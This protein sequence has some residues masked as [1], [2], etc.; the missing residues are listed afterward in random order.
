MFIR[1]WLT[2]IGLALLLS[3]VCLGAVDAHDELVYG[4]YSRTIGPIAIKYERRMSFPELN[5]PAT[6]VDVELGKAIFSFDG[7]GEVRIWPLPDRCPVWSRCRTFGNAR[8]A[9]YICQAEELKVEG[10]WKRYFGFLCKEGAAVVPARDVELYNTYGSPLIR[11][12]STKALRLRWGLMVPGSGH[13]SLKSQEELCPKI[14]DPLHVSLHL[15]NSDHTPLEVPSTWYKNAR[16]GPALREGLTISLHWAGFEPK[17]P[18]AG[19]AND[20]LFMAVDAVGDRHFEPDGG[21]HTLQ[22]AETFEALTLDLHDWFKIERDGYYRVRFELDGDAPGLT[23]RLRGFNQVDA[24]FTIGMPP[25]QPTVAEYNAQIHPLGGP[26]NEER[27]KRLIKETAKAKPR[28]A[29]P[30]PAD[31]EALLAWSKPVNGLAGRIEF[32]WQQRNFWQQKV[33]LV[34]LKNVSDQPLTIPMGNPSDAK[35]PSFFDV[36]AQ[37]GSSPWRRATEFG[38][39]NRYVPAPSDPKA[40]MQAREPLRL[41]KL[42]PSDRPWVTLAPGQESIALAAG[43]DKKDTG[44]AKRVKVVLQQPD[45]SIP[46]RWS[47]VLETPPRAMELPEEQLRALRAVLPFPDHF[48]PLSYEDSRWYTTS[49]VEGLHRSNEPLIDMLPIYDPAGVRKEFDRRMQAEK[50]PQMKLLLASIAAGVGS[51]E[52][53]LFFLETKKDT[54]Y[55]TVLSLHEALW[56]TYVNCTGGPSEWETA[57]LPDWLAELFLTIISD[58]R[59]VTGLEQGNFASGTAFTVASRGS[60]LLFALGKSKYRTVVPLLLERVRRGNTGW[61]TLQALGDIGDQ[62]AIPVLIELVEAAGESWKRS[63]RRRFDRSFEQAAYALSKLKAREAVPVLVK[64]VENPDAIRSLE[65]IGDPRALPVLREVVA[66]RGKIVRDGKHVAPDLDGERLFAARF[67]I[68][69]FDSD[70]EATLLGELLDDPSTTRHQRYNIVMRLGTLD[71]PKAISFLVTIVK[72]EADHHILDMAITGLARFKHKAAVKGLIECFDVPFKEQRFGK[73]GHA[74]PATYR[75]LIARSLQGITGQPFGADK[76]RWHR[77]WTEKGIKYYE[78]GG[79]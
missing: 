61:Y 41:A 37:Q 66:A 40:A 54:D 35:A 20:K 28:E 31:V 51:E 74:T 34:R 57:K 72:T 56:I 5:R 2:T 33:L 52:G 13:L 22:F 44:E 43:S 73:G 25:K 79:P 78:R 71:D 23:D 53:A 8:Q 27:L 1:S 15:L 64:Y 4:R 77:W 50:I 24:V 29:K 36:Y 32:V 48:P 75:N 76:E 68:A 47:G 63:K 67:A 7:L 65:R 19:T 6:K 58:D 38:H 3:R 10:T 59:F 62:R 69:H 30:L 46:G 17:R 11:Y 55:V 49:A 70:N 16:T 21:N 12:K 14:T 39:Y 9:G 18:N 42:P 45:T 60:Q 26:E